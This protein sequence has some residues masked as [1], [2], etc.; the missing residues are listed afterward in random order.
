MVQEGSVVNWVD[1]DLA[2]EL[3]EVVFTR[4]YFAVEDPVLA[5]WNLQ[6]FCNRVMALAD[7]AV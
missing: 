4:M 7:E 2:D 3:A 6:E 5:R 1:S